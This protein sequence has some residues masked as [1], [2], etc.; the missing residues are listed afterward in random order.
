MVSG[1]YDALSAETGFTFP[2]L[3]F[4]TAPLSFLPGMMDLAANEYIAQYYELTAEFD[5]NAPR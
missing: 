3:Q 5:D 4:Q 2:A 1:A